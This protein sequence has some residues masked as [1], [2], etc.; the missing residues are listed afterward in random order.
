[1][2]IEGKRAV[3]AHTTRFKNELLYFSKQGNGGRIATVYKGWSRGWIKLI[4]SGPYIYKYVCVCVRERERERQC[5]RVCVC[6]RFAP[7]SEK[8]KEN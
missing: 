8:I 7:S 3:S 5:A 1:M 6:V 2:Y 4:A